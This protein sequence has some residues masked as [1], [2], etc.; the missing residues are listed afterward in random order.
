MTFFLCIHCS[1]NIT[2]NIVFVMQSSL[3]SIILFPVNIIQNIS[4]RLL[5]NSQTFTKVWG[6]Q[7]QPT[8][9]EFH[10]FSPQWLNTYCPL[11]ITTCL[12]LVISQLLGLSSWSNHRQTAGITFLGKLISG[13]VDSPT[14]LPNINF[15]V[16]V[17]SEASLPLWYLSLP[18]NTMLILE[19][20][21]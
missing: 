12:L 19:F 8:A 11:R 9:Y 18:L 1:Y 7:K 14:L 17:N 5:I 20:L 21:V 6:Y 2:N 4:I 16:P 10:C 3:Q 15:R 13:F